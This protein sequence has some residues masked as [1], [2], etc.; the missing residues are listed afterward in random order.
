MVRQINGVAFA[1]QHRLAQVDAHDVLAEVVVGR[2]RQVLRGIV[3]ERF[4][5]HAVGGDL[6]EHLTI[7][8]AAL[9]HSNFGTLNGQAISQ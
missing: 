9:V 2:L 8:G 1:L 3:L 6:A 4:E 7:C 5:E